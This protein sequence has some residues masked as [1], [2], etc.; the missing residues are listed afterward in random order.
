ML[1]IA[2][3][4]GALRTLSPMPTNVSALIRAK[5]EQYASAPQ[6]QANNV[7]AL[8]GEPGVFRLRVGDWRVLFTEDGVV[9]AVIRVAPR[10]SA[11]D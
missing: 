3:S 9:L 5:V 11:Y 10:S 7:R 1:Q 4:K 6:A 2:Y 8:K